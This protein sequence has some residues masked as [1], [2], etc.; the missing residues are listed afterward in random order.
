MCYIKEMPARHHGALAPLI[1]RSLHISRARPDHRQSQHALRT[2]WLGRP[3]HRPWSSN[4]ACTPCTNCSRKRKS[5]GASTAAPYSTPRIELLAP[6]L[7]PQKSTPRLE[8][9]RDI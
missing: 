1:L 9:C 4:S 7:L 6:E 8:M 3:S 5:P 2:P